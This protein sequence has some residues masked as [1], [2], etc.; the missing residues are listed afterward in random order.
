[1]K[2]VNYIAS[3]WR[4]CYFILRRAA[5]K[6]YSKKYNPRYSRLHDERFYAECL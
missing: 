2:A 6:A 1:M 4:L 5:K 3:T